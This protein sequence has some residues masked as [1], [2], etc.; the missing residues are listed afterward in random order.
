MISMKLNSVL[1]VDYPEYVSSSLEEKLQHFLFVIFNI[2]VLQT[3]KV[4]EFLVHVL[5]VKSVKYYLLILHPGTYF[6]FK[7]NLL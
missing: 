4:T 3:S 1:I 5:S 2:A 7:K 6:P